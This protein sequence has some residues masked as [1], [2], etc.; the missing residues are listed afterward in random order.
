MRIIEVTHPVRTPTCC[1][2][3]TLVFFVVD[4]LIL[5][6]DYLFKKNKITIKGLENNKSLL[7]QHFLNKIT[8]NR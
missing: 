7:L 6:N 2:C 3:V 5:H 1:F 4:I 8:L